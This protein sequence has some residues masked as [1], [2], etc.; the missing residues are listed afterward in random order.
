M[1][2]VRIRFNPTVNGCCPFIEHSAE[3]W[4]KCFWYLVHEHPTIQDMETDGF[5]VR[6]VLCWEG[7]GDKIEW[8]D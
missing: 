1:K 6:A 8:A 2:T 3:T 5:T 4:S 7:E